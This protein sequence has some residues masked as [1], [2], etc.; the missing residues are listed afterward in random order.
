[1]PRMFCLQVLLLGSAVLGST[2][3]KADET[4]DAQASREA[5][6]EQHVRPILVNHCLE[7]HGEKKQEAGLRLDA[8]KFLTRPGDSGPPVVPGKPDESLLVQAV[9]YAGDTKM[10]PKGKLSDAEISALRTWIEQGAAYP[11]GTTDSGP[12]LGWSATPEGIQ[13]SRSTHWSYQPIR[14]PTPP[15]TSLSNWSQQ[16][17]DRFIGQT[18]EANGLKPSRPADRRTLLRRVT[19]D[20]IG[21]PATHDEVTEF[22]LDTSPDAYARVIDRLIASPHYGERWGRHWLDVA[23]YADTKGY[24]FTEERKYPFSYTYRD[25]VIDAFNR[26]L[27]FDQFVREQLA[28][29]QFDP[30]EKSALAAM[31]FLT[32]GR[33]FGNNP[34]DIIDDRIDVVTRGL[35]GLTVTCARCHDHKF[36]AIPTDDYYSLYGIFAS[37]TEPAELPQLGLPEDIA[38][39]QKFEEELQQRKTAVQQFLTATEAEIRDTLRSQA[40]PYLSAVMMPEPTPSNSGEE[41]KKPDELKPLMIQRWRNY[42]ETA[43]KEPHPVFGPWKNLSQ[44]P[45]E[46]FAEQAGMLVSQLNDAAEAAPRT[47]AAVKRALQTSQLST[48][49][50][51]PR[52]YGELLA[53]VQEEWMKLRDSGRPHYRI[54]REE[55]RQVLYA[56]AGPFALNAD[57]AKQFFGRDKKNKI[58]ELQKAVDTFQATSPAAPPRAMVMI[59][60]PQPNPARVFQRGNPGRPGKE[61]PRQFLQVLQPEPKPF[62]QGSGRRELAEAVALPQNPLTARVI[63]NRLWQHHFGTGLVRTPSDFGIRGEP[64]SHPELLDH[65]ARNLIDSGWSLKWL[66]RQLVQSAT[67]HQSSDDRPDGLQRDPEN[68]WL[69]KMPRRRLEFEPLRDSLLA[70][71]G[72][73]DDR[74]HGRGVD[75][76][77][78]NYSRRRAVYGFID[79]QDLPGTFR[80]FDFP[81]PDVSMAMRAETTVPQQLLFGMN[82]ALVVEQARALGQRIPIT[83]PEAGPGVEQ[84]Y[85]QIYARLPTPGGI[86]GG[87]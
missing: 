34:H 87:D 76:F 49:D 21:L 64:P 45:A 16:P 70:V 83:S 68:R 67:Y 57:E 46:A 15:E 6:F 20:L 47:N 19:F 10:P 5:F 82:S 38:A 63:T 17:L 33:R 86:C 4:A 9:G 54:R 28:A 84:L 48:R 30:P 62:Q 36:D 25:Y 35:L 42:L 73:L 77:G 23:R 24:V 14:K 22:E 69:W 72:D 39:Y 18:L 51:V 1:M 37:S 53:S 11:G 71:A 3:V 52:I 50:D 81:S 8:G 43:T 65:L 55:I 2:A 56:D 26:D 44:L 61:V 80:V 29:D 41:Q 40:G 74:L 32:V 78:A 85:R 60:A 13:Q 66:H 12:E 75:L 59:D 7:C 79:R 31:G 27:P 58:R